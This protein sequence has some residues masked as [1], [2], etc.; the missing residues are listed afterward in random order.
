[1]LD[2]IG[3]SMTP[4]DTLANDLNEL[5]S[6]SM[7]NMAGAALPDK[8]QYPQ[9]YTAFCCSNEPLASLNIGMVPSAWAAFQTRVE[10]I[11]V[12][13]TGHR[14]GL[15]RDNQAWQKDYSD[16]EFLWTTSDQKWID[17]I[18]RF[19]VT[20][21][22]PTLRITGG[23]VRMNYQQTV[24]MIMLKIKSNVERFRARK[25]QVGNRP[26]L[27]TEKCDFKDVFTLQNDEGATLP[28][29]TYICGG[30][31][32]GKTASMRTLLK[33]L[34]STQGVPVYWTGTYDINTDSYPD[35]A[36]FVIDDVF[37]PTPAGAHAYVCFVNKL[38]RT[39]RLVVISNYG[40]QGT[41]L[42]PWRLASWMLGKSR[43]TKPVEQISEE[44]LHCPGFVRRAGWDRDPMMRIVYWGPSGPICKDPQGDT[45]IWDVRTLLSDWKVHAAHRHVEIH[46]ARPATVPFSMEE[47]DL[48]L[49][50]PNQT[51]SELASLTAV[52]NA[53]KHTSPRFLKKS[54]AV[55]S[56]FVNGRV[57]G[58]MPTLAEQEIF[59]HGANSII[60]GIKA[61]IIVANVDVWLDGTE[62]WVGAIME[63]N[64]VTIHDTTAVFSHMMD[65]GESKVIHVRRADAIAI[66]LSEWNSCDDPLMYDAIQ[67]R[68]FFPK[69]WA[70]LCADPAWQPTFREKVVAWKN[71]LLRQLTL[72]WET[73][74]KPHWWL[75]ALITTLFAGL[76]TY[77]AI[78]VY[79]GNKISDANVDLLYVA[80]KSAMQRQGKHHKYPGEYGFTGSNK[81]GKLESTTGKGDQDDKEEREEFKKNLMHTVNND[82]DLWDGDRH[83]KVQTRFS[84][85]LYMKYSKSKKMFLPTDQHG[86][87][88]D[89]GTEKPQRWDMY[90]GRHVDEL[91]S[92]KHADRFLRNIVGIERSD[93]GTA[94]ALMLNTSIGVTSFHCTNDEPLKVYDDRDKTIR[95]GQ[96]IHRNAEREIAFISLTVDEAG[97]YPY[98]GCYQSLTGYL[99][100]ENQLSAVKR[101]WIAIAR[102]GHTY[103]EGG[104]YS[105][106][107]DMQQAGLLGTEDWKVGGRVAFS[108]NMSVTTLGTCGSPVFTLVDGS[109]VLLGIHSAYFFARGSSLS[110]VL[111]NEAWLECAEAQIQKQQRM[112]D[113]MEADFL[114]SSL[115]DRK[116]L[117]RTFTPREVS[118][119]FTVRG[120]P[121]ALTPHGPGLE[122]KAVVKT[123]SKSDSNIKMYPLEIPFVSD[124]FPLDRI[125]VYSAEHIKANFPDK[126]PDDAHGVKHVAYIRAIACEQNVYKPE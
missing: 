6:A 4:S 79:A 88:V 9:F 103:V 59:V 111:C 116:E 53:A 51:I 54:P 90:N 126:I 84:D 49:E 56:S 89:Y 63:N 72:F 74:I 17:S 114:H 30:S 125:P 50:A 81:G 80:V 85:D 112:S 69:E 65:D 13:H 118:N 100:P 115:V 46:L 105:Y 37:D 124:A 70:Q 45:A 16:I 24:A 68:A 21:K 22:L 18:N 78:K 31:G 3:A 60:P 44:R 96:V 107:I 38:K 73:Y 104:S 122:F 39:Q 61:R 11:Q 117:A 92:E 67:A 109:P 12:T 95:Y 82:R 48:W 102:P 52:I 55:I 110:S 25:T 7:K 26:A 27:F 29:V 119:F 5:F 76:A 14:D 101:A 108:T 33:G 58:G 15:S 113:Y 34:S 36:C 35:K 2:E 28:H 123:F 23:K 93:G 42:L 121:P 19:L 71:W 87:W 94:F 86:S 98:Q 10:S 40:P 97:H 32:V 43:L 77:A 75:V 62:M 1:M 8:H 106:H 66:M 83:F 64:Y 57:M 99:R 20:Q 91:I 120:D 41:G 47:S